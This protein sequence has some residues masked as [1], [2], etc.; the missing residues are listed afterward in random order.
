MT[1]VIVTRIVGLG[2]GMNILTGEVA[3][4]VVFFHANPAVIVVRVAGL[5][6][7]QPL[8]RQILSLMCIPIPPHSQN[9]ELLNICYIYFILI[10]KYMFL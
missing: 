8:S 3:L 6:P 7:A 9:L 1:L 2:L 5:E 10:S 4:N